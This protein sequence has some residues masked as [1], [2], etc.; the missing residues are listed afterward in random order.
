[1]ER[2]R[3][4]S[5]V[6][7]MNDGAGC[8]PETC[9]CRFCM[10]RVT[11]FLQVDLPQRMMDTCGVFA[12]RPCRYLKPIKKYAYRK[13]IQYLKIFICRDQFGTI[14]E[15]LKPEYHWLEDDGSQSSS[16]FSLLVAK[17]EFC[18]LDSSNGLQCDLCSLMSDMRDST[19]HS[20]AGCSWATGR[21]E[22]LIN[23]NVSSNF[24]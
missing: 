17:D 12:C 6:P 20:H 14:L 7:N 4:G 16:S 13:T 8:E 9:C 21:Q 10:E 19:M 18:R 23:P 22:F 3:A 15:A 1:M 24:T 5:N 11:N 2:C